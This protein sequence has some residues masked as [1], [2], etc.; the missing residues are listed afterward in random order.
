[1]TDNN[2][3]ANTGPGAKTKQPSGKRVTATPK[4]IDTLISDFSKLTVDGRKHG[5]REIIAAL[6]PDIESALARGIRLAQLIDPLTR[7][8]NY[9]LRV[10]ELRRLLASL[11]REAQV[12]DG[13]LNRTGDEKAAVGGVE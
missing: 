8:L 4:Q 2:D 10:E 13:A 9:P 6:L 3:I 11:K 7:R 5:L 12:A 1:V